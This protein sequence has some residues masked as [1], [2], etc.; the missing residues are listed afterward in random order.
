MMD[1]LVVDDG[2]RDT[3]ITAWCKHQLSKGALVHFHVRTA[4]KPS[5]TRS[6][7]LHENMQ[8]A[9]DWALAQDYDLMLMS[10]DDVQCLWGGQDVLDEVAGFF[11][12]CES[13]FFLQSR[14][15]KRGARYGIRTPYYDEGLGAYRLNRA[16]NDVGFFSL[17]RLRKASFR[18]GR[19]EFDSAEIADKLGFHGYQMAAPIMADIP[20]R[21]DSLWAIITGKA[22]FGFEDATSREH[23]S[24]TRSD[25]GRCRAPPGT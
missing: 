22:N 18:F 23:P 5:G 17:A 8:Y 7:G 6:G 1:V 2:S 19:N 10:Q 9:L 3:R 12:R 11:Q 4:P 25:P 15:S 20:M 24:S 16:C 14:F 13:T 21:V